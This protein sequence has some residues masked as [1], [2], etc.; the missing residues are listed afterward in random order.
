VQVVGHDHNGIQLEWTRR[1]D[2]PEGLP[3]GVH[4]IRGAEKRAAFL[5]HQGKEE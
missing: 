3:Q 5:G 1:T 2:H 4:R